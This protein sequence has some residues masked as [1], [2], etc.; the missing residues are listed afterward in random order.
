MK[1]EESDDARASTLGEEQEGFVWKWIGAAAVFLLLSEFAF[2]ANNVTLTGKVTDDAG[3]PIEHATVMVYHAGVKHGYSTFC[4]SCYPDCGKRAFTDASGTYSFTSLNPDLWFE[5]IVVHDGYV[6]LSIAK[7]DPYNGPPRPA[8]LKLRTGTEDLKRTVLGRVVDEH[9]NPLRDV[10]VQPKGIEGDQGAVIG[11]IP[12]L[13]PLG[14]TNDNGEFEISYL[15]PTSEMLL[16]VEARNKAPK[17]VVMPTGAERRTVELHEGALIRGRLVKDGHPV[18]GAEIGLIARERGGF[19]AELN[20]VGNPYEEIRVGTQEDGTFLL[21]NVPF[22]VEW[23]LYGKMESLVGRGTAEPLSCTTSRSKQLLDVGDIQVTPG[24]RLDGR[25]V[26]SD[27]K[28]LPEGMRVV[29]KSDRAW[30]FQTASLGSDGRFEFA[31]LSAGSYSI[32]PSVRGYAL[33]K[34]AF[35]V[36]VFIDRDVSGWTI[37]LSPTD[38]APTSH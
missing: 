4:P 7:V 2:G 33:P 13:D 8:V 22:P 35:E 36:S 15:K 34:G 14:V 11:T 32:T 12:G 1:F 5:L 24:H 27:G 9:G 16:S 31:G 6:P 26:L 37:V 21:A 25:V 17:Y 19:G 29:I 38:R 30:D 28:P 20:L 18:G 23:F 3:K 10:A